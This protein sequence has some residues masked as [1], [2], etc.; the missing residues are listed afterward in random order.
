MQHVEAPARVRETHVRDRFATDN[1]RANGR[2]DGWRNVDWPIQAAYE[3]GRLAGAPGD[4]GIRWAAIYEYA[5][6][7]ALALS[8]SGRDSTDLDI[9]SGGSGFPISEAQSD[10]VKKLISIDSHMPQKDRLIVR[11]L[12][13]GYTMAE[14]VNAA[15]GDNFT[16]TVPARV[17]DALDA[18]DEAITSAR[19]GGYRYVR[20]TRD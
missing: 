12:C 19:Q 14:A 7:F 18:L 13:E 20:M 2:P 17:R 8:R 10:A 11:K 9:V 15:C 4:A 16:H 3:K 5:G 1:A 6:I